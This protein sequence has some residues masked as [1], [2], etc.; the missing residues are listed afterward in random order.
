MYCGWFS[1]QSKG[2]VC[3]GEVGFFG[4]DDDFEQ[5]DLLQDISCSLAIL[6]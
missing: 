3:I 4:A 6:I 1:Y 5:D 2:V